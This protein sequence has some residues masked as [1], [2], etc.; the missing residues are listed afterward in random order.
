[1]S[2]CIASTRDLSPSIPSVCVILSLVTYVG[3]SNIQFICVAVVSSP[4]NTSKRIHMLI[5]YAWD[6]NGPVIVS[7]RCDY[8]SHQAK[9]SSLMKGIIFCMIVTRAHRSVP[10]ESQIFSGQ[11]SRITAGTHVLRPVTVRITTQVEADSGLGKDSEA[12][13]TPQVSPRHLSYGAA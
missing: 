7:P 5:R 12:A 10:T 2:Y 13:G 4:L 3:N 6:K 9:V 1:M 8:L 11:S